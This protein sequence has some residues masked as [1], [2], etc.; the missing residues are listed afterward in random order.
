MDARTETEVFADLAELCRSPGF[1]HAIVYFDFRDNLI[2]FGDR[3][4]AEAME[5]QHAAERLV[6]TEIA[7]MIGLMVQ[8]PIDAILPIP[9]RFQEYVDRA[10]A[11]LQELHWAMSASWRD[12]FKIVDGVVQIQEPMW[13]GANLREPIFYSGESAYGFQ[14]RALAIRKY[15]ADNPWL[16]ANKG[17]EI[18]DAVAVAQ[19]LAD[20]LSERQMALSK[21]MVEL[22]P[23]QWTMLPGSVFSVDDIQGRCE[24]DRSRIEAVL[25]AFTL[26]PGHLNPRFTALHEFNATNAMPLLHWDD[27]QFLLLQHY[28]LLE[29]IYESPVFWLTEDRT[30]APTAVRHRGE[31]TEDFAAECLEK[32]FGKARVLRNIDIY[33]PDRNRVGEI[34]ALAIY[35][36]RAILLQAKSKRLTI[37]ARKGNDLQLKDDFKKAVQDA[38]DQAFLCATALLDSSFKL[39]NAAGDGIELPRSFDVVQPLCI[40]SDHYPALAFQASAFLKQRTTA[41]IVAPLV[42][43]VFALDVMAEML[44]GPLQFLHYLTLRE[45]FGER[46]SASH[47]LTLLGYHLTH[48]LWFDDEFNMMVMG[49]DFSIPLDIAMLA[50]RE[51]LPGLET[52]EGIL[53][54]LK[55]TTFD[56]LVAQIESHDDPDIGELGLALLQLGE[57]T[58]R[59]LG[60]GIDTLAAAARRDRRPHDLSL[61]FGEAQA[62]L[63][64]HCRYPDTPDT[65][66]RLWAHCRLRKYASKADRWYGLLIHPDT[67]DVLASVGSLEPWTSD[68][69]MEEQVKQ[70][71]VR[72]QVPW[73][74]MRRRL[75]QK[76][77]RNDPCACGSGKKHKK[78]CLV[79]P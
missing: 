19:T 52:P 70:W 3:L 15:A 72:P 76:V 9:E 20:V 7:T 2:R 64:V 28:S 17:F 35:G 1:I 74:A 53:T 24:L 43:D 10:Q 69:E 60:S 39:K 59:S 55:G 58:A 30:Y 47:E 44:V 71:P 46:L 66:L 23:D 62:G 11:L 21:A 50:R 67:R 6:R 42:M 12:S 65:M 51:G 38:A 29:A 31:F 68:A 41:H 73:S 48:H 26:P 22:P 61:E 75:A 40:V 57:E 37:E 36:R 8:G 33:G 18:G 13:A 54:K 79:R 77:G 16:L 78:C 32:V 45:R 27:G 56:R 49:D 14:Y 5:S 63:T 4:D 34:D 25:A